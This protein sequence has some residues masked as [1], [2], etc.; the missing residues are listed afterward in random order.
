[1]RTNMH[2]EMINLVKSLRGTYKQADKDMVVEAINAYKKQHNCTYKHAYE[3][4]V[5]GN[6]SYST[7]TLWR[8]KAESKRDI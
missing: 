8:R 1:M 7:Y 6:P 4:T 5:D 3:M 2:V